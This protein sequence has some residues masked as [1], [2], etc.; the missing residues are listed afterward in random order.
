MN[1]HLKK[2][3]NNVNIAYNIRSQ[4]IVLVEKRKEC[5][6]VKEVSETL[7]RESCIWR[8][9]TLGG[10]LRLFGPAF[11]FLFLLFFLSIRV[12]R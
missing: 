2:E 6:H 9:G 4:M 12:P 8:C 3:P 1:T 11:L 10:R 7:V 5:E